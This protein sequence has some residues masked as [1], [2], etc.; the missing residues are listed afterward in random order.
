MPLNTPALNAAIYAAFKKL[1]SKPGPDKAGIEMQLAKDL[2]MAIL[3]YVKSGPIVISWLGGIGTIMSQ[4]APPP[5]PSHVAA[6]T[7]P[8]PYRPPTPPDPI[9]TP[10]PPTSHNSS[11]PPSM[12][13]SDP[14]VNPYEPNDATDIPSE[15]VDGTLLV[16]IGG[17]QYATG[18]WMLDKIPE[19]VKKNRTIMTYEHNDNYRDIIKDL[20]KVTYTKLEL[21]A[22]SGGGNNAFKMLNKGI[23][24]DFLGLIDPSVPKGYAEKGH[25]SHMSMPRGSNTV[26]FFNHKNWGKTG[27]VGRIRKALVALKPILTEEGHNVNEEE[28]SH[29]KMPKAFF[30]RYMK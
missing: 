14:V 6:S 27:G 26:F 3:A 21:T 5:S 4:G 30:E 13:Q 29:K 25:K 18:K 16:V 12:T 22:F 2:S 11:P 7:V 24:P 15:A 19:A 23:K 10:R 8:S 9:Y 28:M 17:I 1:S 20:E